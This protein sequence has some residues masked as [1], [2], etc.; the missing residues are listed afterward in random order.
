[1]AS[2]MGC[3]K[4]GNWIHGIC[5]KIMRVTTTLATYFV[6]STCR[7]IMEGTVDSIQKLCNRMKTANEFCYLGDKW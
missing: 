5:T 3:T 2:S 7:G 1:M 6:C 4:C